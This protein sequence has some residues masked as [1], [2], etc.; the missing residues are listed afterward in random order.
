MSGDGPGPTGHTAAA[1]PAATSPP[2]TPPLLAGRA[3]LVTGGGA[4]IG[5]ATCEAFAAHGASVGVNDV[6]PALAS[7]VVEGIVS[8]GGRA[9]ALPGDVRIPEVVDGIVAGVLEAFGRLEVLVNNVGHFGGPAVPF[10]ES[11]DEQWQHLYEVNL[12]HVLRVTR[13]ALPHLR[14]AGGGS[15]INLTTVEAFRGI[16][17]HPVY[18]A[19]KAGVTQFSKSLALQV[20]GDGIRVND[21]APDV[22]RSAQLPYERWLSDDDVAR[23][24]RWVPLGRLGEPVD[25]AGVAVFLASDLSAFVT[26]TTIHCD[27]GTWAAG[28]WYRTERDRRGWT[29]RPFDP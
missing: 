8:A 17:Q 21:I 12:L 16:P 2:P 11:T 19:F 13:A 23:I 27:G 25:P 7:E 3:A 4:G 9:V 5:R 14:A 26:G 10:E 22:T 29:N 24:P 20:G 1:M 28:G 18:A 15:I 6:D